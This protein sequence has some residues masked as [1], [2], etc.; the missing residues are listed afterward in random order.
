[1]NIYNGT[2]ETSE[3]V[4][5][6]KT[7]I[8]RAF[9]KRSGISLDSVLWQLNGS[10]GEITKELNN[11][12]Y[13][14][15]MSAQGLEKDGTW[16]ISDFLGSIPSKCIV[17]IEVENTTY[18][19]GFPS[20][21]TAGMLTCINMLSPVV[22]P[23]QPSSGILFYSNGYGTW[24]ASYRMRKIQGWSCA[25]YQNGSVGHPTGFTAVKDNIYNTGLEMHYQGVVT[26]T[27]EITTTKTVTTFGTQFLPEEGFRTVG[28][29]V[30][31]NGGTMK[32]A[33]LCFS[34]EGYLQITPISGTIPANSTI[35]MNIIWKKR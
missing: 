24:I 1:M 12:K 14:N 4:A 7:F 15:D 5:G 16:T 31:E 18:E 32:P 29:C 26:N 22:E 2:L 33:M 27:T 11:M 34:T 13:I 8:D 25:T 17:Q 6:A 19:R 9:S 3:G 21:D 23:Y 20:I 10:I 28:S 35:I 30:V